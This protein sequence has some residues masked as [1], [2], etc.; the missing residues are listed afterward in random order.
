VRILLIEDDEDDYVLVQSLLLQ[1]ASGQYELDWVANWGAALEKIDHGWHD[2][3]LL[4]YSLGEHNGLEL[5]RQLTAK[6]CRSPI[7]FL[8]GQGDYQVDVE[9]MKGGA[10]DYLLKAQL[11]APL[12]ERS[13]R[14]SIEHKRSEESLRRLNRTLRTLSECNQSVVHAADESDLLHKICR[15]IVEIG[16]HRM[17]WVSLTGQDDE[18]GLRSAAAMAY[19]NGYLDTAGISGIHPDRT[20]EP[21]G[22][23]LRTGRPSIA[24]NILRNPDFAPWRDEAL[25][26][27]YASCIALPL[28]AGGKTFG[29]LN[30]HAREPDAFDEEEVNLLAEL[31]DDL[32]YGMM[33]LRTRE[34]RDRAKDDLQRQLDFLQHL[35]DTIPNPIFYKD[36]NGLYQGC[37]RAFE[38][39][40]GLTKGQIIGKTVYDI[41]PKAIADESREMD[42]A[43]LTHPGVQVYESGVFHADGT[44]RDVIFNRAATLNPDGTAAGL[45][46][47]IIDITDRKRAEQALR[48][49]EEL[50]R[51]TLGNISDTVFITDDSGA[52]VYICSNIRA[53]FGFSAQ[54]VLEMGNVSRLIGQDIVDLHELEVLG[55]I[56]NTEREVLDSACKKHILLI[57]VKRVNI[58]N[59]TV[60]YTCHDITERRQLEEEQVRLA[61]AFNQ[62]AEEILVADTDWKIQCVNRAYEKVS[63]F[64]REEVIGRQPRIFNCTRQGVEP[65]RAIQET[66]SCGS[67]WRGHLSI[68]KK[69]GTPY[70]VEA[71]VSPVR[72]SLGNIINFVIVK[73]DVTHEIELE[74]QLRQMQKAEALGTLAGGIAHDFNNILGI[75]LGFTELAMLHADQEGPVLGYLEQAFKAGHRARDLVAQILAFSRH[76]KQER[77]PLQ[78]APVVKEILKLLR[79]SLP[80]T[81][82]IRQKILVSEGKDSVL[83]D[84]TQ[85]HQVLMNLCTNAAHAMRDKGGVLEV[86]LSSVFLGVEEACRITGPA[87]ANYVCLVVADTGHGIDPSIMDRIFDPYFTTKGTGE[88]TGLGLAVVQGIVKSHGGGITVQSEVGKGTTFK[89]FLPQME[90]GADL[91]N[92]IPQSM[93]SGRET[94][95]LVDDEEA[96]LNAGRLML[97]HL[98]YQVVTER[99]SFEALETFR[100]QPYAFDLVITDLTMPRMTGIDLAG[101]LLAIRPDIRIVLCTG[102]SDTT[103]IE[104]LKAAG[105]LELITKPLML[106]DLAETVRKVLDG[107]DGKTGRSA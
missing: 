59:G 101:S 43:L 23:A 16:G 29:S 71:T 28:T 32:A 65:A 22:R 92:L 87:S 39:Y 82:E 55:E 53:I 47:V 1:I 103:T 74:N 13:I 14:Y 18:Q 100:A 102:F 33:A 2:V 105:I 57:N 98:G 21:V 62:V 73:R 96:L 58:K 48:E 106:H 99:G 40:L 20:M 7:I 42:Q 67:V 36:M 30:I 27:G 56:R 88:G 85:I 86:T 25:K 10:A 38:Y 78:F 70:E 79:A 15:I 49:S 107:V 84:P 94:I 93:P 68:D 66:L 11:N 34:E 31:T 72:D 50:H 6:G 75:I 46:G 90:S 60:L 8:T 19:E 95:L 26:G 9:A 97:E 37:N 24:R 41:A 64:K 51:I 69:D 81:I 45:V 80:T 61:T 83:A 63:G 35:I 12:L 52:F 76:C 3:Y 4:D 89:I 91:D 17:A 104:R 44:R 77:K 54:E 5:L